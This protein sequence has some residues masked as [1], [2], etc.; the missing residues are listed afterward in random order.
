LQGGGNGRLCLRV[1]DIRAAVAELL[2]K[3]VPADNPESK[4]NGLLS[5]FR[6]PDGN[7]ICLWQYTT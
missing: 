5:P 2:S 4:A 3:G 7:E 1:D 6:D